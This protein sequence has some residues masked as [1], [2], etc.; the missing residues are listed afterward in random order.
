MK[1][2]NDLMFR[3]PLDEWSEDEHSNEVFFSMTKDQF[4]KNY[5]KYAN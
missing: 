3:Y 1:G 2:H 4:K 5:I